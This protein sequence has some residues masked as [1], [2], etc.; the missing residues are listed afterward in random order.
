MQSFSFNTIFLLLFC[1][2]GNLPD[3]FPFLVQNP[4]TTNQLRIWLNKIPKV[5]KDVSNP[6]IRTPNGS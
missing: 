4:Q 3:S 5:R 1:L 2:F 6:L